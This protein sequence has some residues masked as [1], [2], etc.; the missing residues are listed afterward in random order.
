MLAD[1]IT[2]PRNN[3]LINIRDEF[4]LNEP[5]FSTT[6]DM[7]RWC[8][9][10]YED[11]D[12]ICFQHTA[13]LD[14]PVE[15]YTYSALFKKITQAANLFTSISDKTPIVSYLLPNLPQTHF[16]IWGAEAVGIV[17]AINPLLESNKVIDIITAA[18]SNVLVTLA[19]EFNP[20]LW[21]KALDA[22]RNSPQ[23]EVV[24]LVGTAQ[25]SEDVSNQVG[26]P[27]ISFDATLAQQNEFNL[28][29]EQC[30]SANDVAAYFHTGGTTGTPKVAQQTHANQIANAW[31][32]TQF[33]PGNVGD[34]CLVGLPLFHVNAVIGTGLAGFMKGNCIVLLTAMGY[35]TPNVINN[36][37]QYVKKYQATIFSCVPTILTALLDSPMQD[38]D[39]SSLEFV[40]CGAAPL[41]QQLMTNFEATTGAKILESYGLTEASCIST[42]NPIEGERK[43]GSIGVCLP[44]QQIK[45]VELDDAGKIIK[46]CQTN[47]VGALLIKGDNVFPGYLEAKS[48][49]GTLLD[50]GWLNTGDLGRLDQDGFIWLTGR[51][52]DLIIR[53]GH[54][55]DP[56]CIEETL[57]SHQDVAS[58]AAIGQPDAYAGELPC[59]YITLTPN[60]TASLEEIETFVRKNIPER[61][62]TPV[63]LEVMASLPVTAVG[64]IFKPSLRAKAA[65]RVL[66]RLFNEENIKAA[67]SVSQQ[68][69]GLIAEIITSVDSERIAKVMS[70]LTIEYKICLEEK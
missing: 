62:A 4:A 43:V 22:I 17:N 36:F 13:A 44:N 39:I 58:V 66:N 18:N 46:E 20:E 25:V 70:Q 7:F 41:S 3:N 47:E 52:K 54:N 26:I 32:L 27:V 55:I 42:L 57:M 65:E 30:V 49:I 12:A 64:K 19:P 14:S 10:K 51:E 11:L 6:Y 69:T 33:Y 8:A 23:I 35:R 53:G 40:I 60:A 45:I 21:N 68:K 61:A 34:V 37:W 31:S 50:N 9:D 67:A 38:A 48:N 16:T 28:D 15:K 29:N 1:N 24:L 63:Y 5:P 56:S 59:A 2:N